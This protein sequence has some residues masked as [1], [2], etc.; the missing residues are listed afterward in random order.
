MLLALIRGLVFLVPQRLNKVRLNAD[1]RI[2]IV[3]LHRDAARSRPVILTGLERR[4]IHELPEPGWLEA[5]GHVL[6]S[7]LPV[8]LVG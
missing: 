5:D 4:R 2:R 7:D 1:P 6:I 3:C 8:V